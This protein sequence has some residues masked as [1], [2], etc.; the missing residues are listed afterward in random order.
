MEHKDSNDIEAFLR[1][2]NGIYNGIKI[3]IISYEMSEEEYAKFYED[4]KDLDYFS[5]SYVENYEIVSRK[6]Y[7]LEKGNITTY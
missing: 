5:L 4:S 7:S 1:E 6:I 3:Q 2:L